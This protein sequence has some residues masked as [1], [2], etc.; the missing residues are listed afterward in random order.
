MS[1]GCASKTMEAFQAEGGVS[2]RETPSGG[3]FGIQ[4]FAEH[5]HTLHKKGKTTTSVIGPLNSLE[6]LW[7]PISTMG[8]RF[9]LYRGC[10][11]RRTSVTRSQV[12]P[13]VSSYS[14]DQQVSV[15]PRHAVQ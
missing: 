8:P 1:L 15:T 10:A 4:A 14:T 9:G 7:S 13:S 5:L 3:K 6:T 11:S 12:T 2:G